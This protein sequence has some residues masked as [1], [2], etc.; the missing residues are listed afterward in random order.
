[1]KRRQ[2]I[3][4]AVATGGA[5]LVQST[6]RTWGRKLLSLMPIAQVRIHVLKC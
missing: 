1:M 2:F 3:G 6:Q 4:A 5:L